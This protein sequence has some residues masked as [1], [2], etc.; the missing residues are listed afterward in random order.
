MEFSGVTKEFSRHVD[1]SLW[2]KEMFLVFNFNLGGSIIPFINLAYHYSTANLCSS[3]SS[4]WQLEEW[5]EIERKR[6]EER[7]NI[8]NVFDKSF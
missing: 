1:N 8:K 6:E 7:L 4:S 2:P 3:S 5:T